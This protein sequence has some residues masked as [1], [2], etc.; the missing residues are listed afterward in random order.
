VYFPVDT[1]QCMLMLYLFEPLLLAEFLKMILFQ[2][3]AS[4]CKNSGLLQ[5]VAYLLGLRKENQYT[6][7]VEVKVLKSKAL[8]DS[9][10]EI[11]AGITMLVYYVTE[12]AARLWDRARVMRVAP[13][14][15]V[16][17]VGFYSTAC[18]ATWVGWSVTEQ[19]PPPDEIESADELVGLVLVVTLIRVLC[20]AA[21]VVVLNAIQVRFE[22]IV[23]GGEEGGAG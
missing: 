20:L 19:I 1:I 21:E 8:V 6:D 11:L 4:M 13:V 18:M 17:F 5:L 7:P 3:F 10:S 12:T 15:N 16:T 2:E 9:L 22:E 23:G 14:T